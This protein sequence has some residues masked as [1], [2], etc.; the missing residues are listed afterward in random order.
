M[1]KWK[2][3]NNFG[4]KNF[5][6]F[7]IQSKDFVSWVKESKKHIHIFSKT[8]DHSSKIDLNCKSKQENVEVFNVSER[9]SC[10]NFL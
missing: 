1:E 3:R 7:S 2:W 8:W 10:E 5:N 4:G 9:E 6:K